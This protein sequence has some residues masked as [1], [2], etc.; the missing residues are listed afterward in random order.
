MQ[1]IIDFLLEYY[2]VVLVVLVILLIT[3]IGFLADTKRK[4]KMREKVESEN[5]SSG[6][7]SGVNNNF[8]NGFSDFN[9]MNMN[10]NF[11]NGFNMAPGF[12]NNMNNQNMITPEMGDLNN[13][14]NNNMMNNFNQNQDVNA[15]INMGMN[16]FNNDLNNNFNNL[17]QANNINSEVSNQSMNNLNSLNNNQMNNSQNDTFFV[18]ASE[19]TPKI[20]PREVVI[21]KPVEP[22]PIFVGNEAL[23]GYNNIDQGP[24]P[25]PVP[26]VAPVTPVVEPNIINTQNMGSHL[27]AGHSVLDNTNNIVKAPEPIKENFNTVSNIGVNPTD[28]NVS[29]IPSMDVSTSIPSGVTPQA[30]VTPNYNSIQNVGSPILN[31]PPVSEPQITNSGTVSGQ[32]TIMPN[33]G[34]TAGG[35]LPG[36]T[37]FVVGNPNGA[38]N[39]P[40]NNGN[41]NWNL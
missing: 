33:A 21:P 20:E 5:A 40:V 31:V 24:V 25:T 17:N 30:P 39:N 8:N 12:D 13:N 34:N 27:N 4:K 36:G 10:N 37:N 18:P 1:A 41:D 15:G 35:P 6:A 16:N 32:N 26:N 28:V 19:Q 38:V 29:P 3:I 22:S 9:S 2:V 11:N 7:E 23:N 14:F